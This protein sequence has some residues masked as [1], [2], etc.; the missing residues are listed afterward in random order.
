MRLAAITFVKKRAVEIPA[1]LVDLGTRLAY[2]S[3]KAAATAAKDHC[4]DD[5][6][7]R[8]R[9]ALDGMERGYASLSDYG[10]AFVREL[11]HNLAQIAHICRR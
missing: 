9:S 2:S 4:P 7:P 3:L 1:N 10:G 6:V 5:D 11:S 8:R